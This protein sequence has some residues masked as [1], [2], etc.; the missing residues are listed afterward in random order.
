MLVCADTVQRKEARCMRCY[1]QV[2]CISDLFIF[3]FLDY[4]TNSALTTLFLVLDDII[5]CAHW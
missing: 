4:G 3:S 5:R 1:P 2:M